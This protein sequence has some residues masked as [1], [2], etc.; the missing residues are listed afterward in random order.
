MNISVIAGLGN[1]GSEYE[2]T[3]HNIGFKVV[4][5]VAAA[6]GAS[7]KVEKRFRAH[8]AEARIAGRS[9]FLVKPQTYMNRSGESLL[10]FTRFHKLPDSALAVAYDEINLDLCRLKLSQKGSDGG[11]NGVADIIQNV[12]SSFVRVKIGIGARPDKEV[13]L[14]DYVLSGFSVEEQN[15][16][17]SHL[18]SYTEAFQ[19]LVRQGIDRAM[20]TLNSRTKIRKNHESDSNEE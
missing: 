10:S 5:A 18:K 6:S 11:H 7:W 19:L 16:I 9:V 13:D 14:K 12:G 4:D 17:Q 20:N 8:V 3:R 2:N 1:P 15:I